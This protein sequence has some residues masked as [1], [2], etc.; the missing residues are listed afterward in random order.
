MCERERLIERVRRIRRV[1]TS[2]DEPP[3]RSTVNPDRDQPR[4]PEAPISDLEQVV[5]ALADSAPS[6]GLWPVKR[7]AKLAARIQPSFSGTR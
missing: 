2:A 7:I 6:E 1:A 3:R 4:A 5:R